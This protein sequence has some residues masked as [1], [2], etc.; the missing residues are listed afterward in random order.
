MDDTRAHV[1]R[2]AHAVAAWTTLV[3]SSISLLRPD[4]FSSRLAQLSLA[5]VGLC[6]VLLE[7]RWLRQSGLLRL[8]P[9]QIAAGFKRPSDQANSTLSAAAALTW[10]IAVVTHL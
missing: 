2:V 4:L 10:A 9:G 8:T 7:L 6:F 1:R 3:V 5:G